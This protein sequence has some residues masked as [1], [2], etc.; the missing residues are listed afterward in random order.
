MHSKGA[1]CAMCQL[2]GYA[3][4]C[5]SPRALL[6]IVVLVRIG[7]VG[8]VNCLHRCCDQSVG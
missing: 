1:I 2:A 8:G 7:R 5:E 3:I 4:G 6:V